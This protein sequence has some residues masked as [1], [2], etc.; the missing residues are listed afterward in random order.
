MSK[1]IAMVIASKDF[2]D[3]EYKEP[4][5]IMEKEGFNITVFSS[6]L[7][8]SKGMFGFEVKPDK[9]LKDLNPEEFDGVIF[10]GGG[11]S[12]EYF[13]NKLAHKI[14]L[15]FAEMNKLVSAICIAPKTLAKAGLL[16]GKKVCSF[17]SVKDDITSLG[18]LIQKDGV[19]VD[20]NIITATGPDYAEDFG[21]A[22]V[23]FF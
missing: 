15:D 10:V 6:S 18:G 9:L 22:I 20:G 13:E 21:K 17:P 8:T 23:N 11:G 12:A 19:A 1:N 7:S 5:K 14:V 3:E 16:K 2:R 4:R